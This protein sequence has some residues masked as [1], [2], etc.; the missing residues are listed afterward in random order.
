MKRNIASSLPGEQVRWIS[1]HGRVDRDGDG[2]PVLVRGVSRDITARKLAENEIQQQRAEL[3]HVARVSTMGL[4][5]SSLPMKSTN[6]SEPSSEM[7]KPPNYFCR[8]ATL[9]SE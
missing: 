7:L 9:T 5:A 2:E 8:T 4:L 6:R 3:L 1:S